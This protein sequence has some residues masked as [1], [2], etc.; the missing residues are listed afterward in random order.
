[1]KIIPKSEGC[2]W[3]SHRLNRTR[4]KCIRRWTGEDGLCDFH[5]AAVEAEKEGLRK[6]NR[7]LNEHFFGK[8][9]AKKRRRTYRTK[10]Q[11]RLRKR[12]GWDEEDA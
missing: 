1:M 3:G 2:K 12:A 7:S 5:R 9:K 8:P 10:A 6:M 4:K 11:E